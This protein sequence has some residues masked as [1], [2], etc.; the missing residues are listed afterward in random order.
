ML[1]LVDVDQDSDTGW[2]GYD[3]LVNRKVLDG[4]TSEV[5]K[6]VAGAWV[7]T[8]K[9]TFC[10]VGNEMEI[11]VPAELL[12]V[13]GDQAAFDFK[14]ADNPYEL[15]DPISLCLHG[16]TAPNRRFNYRFLWKK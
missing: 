12:R 9:A 8:G 5:S 2:Y 10:V 15:K 3:I 11:S 13:S 16:D 14:W 6:Y 1:L 7:P 4:R